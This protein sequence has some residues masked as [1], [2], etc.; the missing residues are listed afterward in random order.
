MGRALT[1]RQ[2]S[3]FLKSDQ[4]KAAPSE[5]TAQKTTDAVKGTEDAVKETTAAIANTEKAIEE[6]TAAIAR[7]HDVIQATQNEI[8]QQGQ[9]LTSFTI[10]TTA[11]LPLGFCTSVFYLLSVI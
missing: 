1:T 7:T 4:A 2:L 9:T 11:F 10:V 5:K 8:M 3:A 6:T